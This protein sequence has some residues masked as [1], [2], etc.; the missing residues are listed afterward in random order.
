MIRLQVGQGEG[1]YPLTEFQFL[2]D[3]ITSRPALLS[4]VLLSPFQFL[5]DTIT[6]GIIEPA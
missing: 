2:N 1:A 6:S 4:A 5:N 3:T